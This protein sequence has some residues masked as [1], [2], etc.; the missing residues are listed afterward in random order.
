MLVRSKERGTK[1]DLKS[2]TLAQ[3]VNARQPR[4]GKQRDSNAGLP[5]TEDSHTPYSGHLVTNLP[6]STDKRL[7]FRF[8]LCADNCRSLSHACMHEFGYLHTA[9][10][11]LHTC[12]WDAI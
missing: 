5:A 6:G 10:S 4:L 1:V 9:C 2:S 7:M 12:C 11:T 8:L 3:R